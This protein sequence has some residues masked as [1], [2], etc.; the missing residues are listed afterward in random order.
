MN[1]NI[2]LS[3]PYENIDMN[4]NMKF[5]VS[6]LSDFRAQ[7]TKCNAYMKIKRLHANQFIS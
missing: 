4:K 1:F 6:T 2:I 7:N 3:V 5:R